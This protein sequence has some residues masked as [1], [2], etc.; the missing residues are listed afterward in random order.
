MRLHVAREG[1]FVDLYGHGWKA[2]SPLSS[3]SASVKPRV[4]RTA[5][6]EEL[7]D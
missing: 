1:N 7:V 2:V 4:G 6:A 5:A 3:E